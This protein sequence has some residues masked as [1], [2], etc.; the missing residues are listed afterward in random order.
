MKEEESAAAAAELS[1]R[2]RQELERLKER[3]PSQK[4]VS[5]HHRNKA[6]LLSEL[7]SQNPLFKAYINAVIEEDERTRTATLMARSIY[8]APPK[9]FNP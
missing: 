3:Y 7:A 1:E 8:S 2:D 9:K 6:E 5:L 4:I